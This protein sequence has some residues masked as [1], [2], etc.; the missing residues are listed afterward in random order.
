[1]KNLM[2]NLF[3]LFWGIV[4]YGFIGL[5]ALHILEPILML[6]APFIANL[7]LFVVIG[8]ITLFIVSLIAP[9]KQ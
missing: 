6:V 3:V 5:Y 4:I 2:S 9:K 1:M 8:A 7:G